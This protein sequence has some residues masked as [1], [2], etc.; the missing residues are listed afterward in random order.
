MTRRYFRQPPISGF[1]SVTLETSYSRS[2]VTLL[3]FRTAR[4][5]KRAQFITVT[6]RRAACKIWSLCWGQI[7]RTAAVPRILATL[8]LLLNF[9][10]N[11]RRNAVELFYILLKRPSLVWDVIEAARRF[12]T[13]TY[14]PCA[15]FERICDFSLRLIF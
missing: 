1:T 15:F 5:R 12:T 7:V 9:V 8:F 2:A 13:A 14:I 3:I 6:L 11:I 4:L 10:C